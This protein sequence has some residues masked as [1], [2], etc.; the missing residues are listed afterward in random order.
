[1]WVGSGWYRVEV[2]RGTV[3]APVPFVVLGHRRK[4]TRPDRHEDPTPGK[5]VDPVHSSD[6]VEDGR[7]G[8]G[9]V[10]QGDRSGCEREV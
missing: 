1:M 5:R 7:K 2:R 6:T 4:E 10:V 9:R 3:Y 8:R